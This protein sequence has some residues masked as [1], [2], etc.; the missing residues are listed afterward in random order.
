[1]RTRLRDLA[2]AA[3]LPAPRV[4]IVGAVAASASAAEGVLAKEAEEVLDL[5]RR[6]EAGVDLEEPDDIRV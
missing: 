1:V 5:F 2:S 3:A 4:L 6:E